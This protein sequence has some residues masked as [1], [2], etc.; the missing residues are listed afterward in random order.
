MT[1]RVSRELWQS[2]A[3]RFSP[4]HRTLAARR[5]AGAGRTD[6]VDCEDVA[7]ILVVQDYPP[8]AKVVAV[9]AARLGHQTLRVG[10]FARAMQVEDS[11]DAAVVDIELLDGSG[12]A[13]AQ[14]LLETGRCTSFVFFTAS[15]DCELLAEAERLGPVID[16]AD[17]IHGLL[18][19]VEAELTRSVGA[20]PVARVVGAEGQDV[21]SSRTSGFRRRVPL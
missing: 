2:V 17:S 3:L 15:R 7:R 1:P 18:A 10:S 12:I 19:A 21:P 20:A 4:P 13:L 6:D 11:F 9:A 8:L 5:R 16:K 14:R